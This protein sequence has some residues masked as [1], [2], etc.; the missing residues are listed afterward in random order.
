MCLNADQQKAVRAFCNDC[1]WAWSVRTHFR[2]LF[3]CGEA[4]LQLFS[5]VALLFFQDL[6]VVLQEY[7]LLQL[8]KLT[9]PASQ[10]ADKHNLT[11]NYLLTFGWDDRTKQELLEAN[12]TIAA[13]RSRINRARSKLIAHNDLRARLDF[14]AL[15][16][17]SEAEEREFWEA[18]SSFASAC[19]SATFGEPYEI[20]ATMR[21]GDAHSLVQA[22]IDA[23]DYGDMMKETDGAPVDRLDRRR[24][25]DA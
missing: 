20:K 8:C 9:D 12:V 6:N 17:F 10:G 5:E 18:L 16:E 25:G 11:T 2:D 1:V 24:Y 22:M 7:T 23:I 3:E 21:A 19:H 14:N 4:R 13:F 15:G